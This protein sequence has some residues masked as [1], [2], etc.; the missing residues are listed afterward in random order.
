[1]IQCDPIKILWDA[2]YYIL[3]SREKVD[4]STLYLISKAAHEVVIG[5]QEAARDRFIKLRE[6]GKL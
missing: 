3:H 6:E 5:T 1:M 2:Y 4:D